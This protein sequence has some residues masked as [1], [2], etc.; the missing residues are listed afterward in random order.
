MTDQIVVSRNVDIFAGST[1]GDAASTGVLTDADGE[2]KI[3][4]FDGTL[5]GVFDNAPAEG[6]KFL[7]GTDALELTHYGPAATGVTIRQ[8][9]REANNTA[10]GSDADGTGYTIKLTGPGDL[11]RAR[12]EFG[13]LFL[14]LRNTTDKSSVSL[15]TKVNASDDVFGWPACR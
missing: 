2:K 13:G 5:T 9:A 15:S 3:I 12:D 11:V 10:I 1:L 14:I 4:D 7:F 8:A 6:T